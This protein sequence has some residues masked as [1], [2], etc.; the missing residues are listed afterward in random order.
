MTKETL[1]LPE[2]KVQDDVRFARDVIRPEDIRVD[3]QQDGRL[4]EFP[5]EAQKDERFVY[6]WVRVTL[7]GEDDIKNITT[8]ERMGWRFCRPEDIP[9]VHNLPARTLGYCRGA[10]GISDVAVA[11]LPREVA[12]ARRKL[13]EKQTAERMQAI[14]SQLLREGDQRMPTFNESRSTVRTGRAAEFD[15]N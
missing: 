13:H 3:G 11:K 2:R 1:H 14:N 15:A 7:D 10:V 8:A 9:G 4:P 5:E 6:R 12:V